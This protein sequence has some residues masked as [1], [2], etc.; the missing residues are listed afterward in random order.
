M[1][2]NTTSAKGYSSY[3][4]GNIEGS[5]ERVEI[6]SFLGSNDVNAPVEW[7]VLCNVYF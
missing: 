1:H 5:E 3:S 7:N 4:S 2:G 6:G